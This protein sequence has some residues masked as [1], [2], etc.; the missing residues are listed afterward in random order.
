MNT[1]QTKKPRPALGNIKHY[2]NKMY[3]KLSTLNYF[4]LKYYDFSVKAFH[5][6]K[7]K[8]PNVFLLKSF[9]VYLSKYDSFSHKRCHHLRL[10]PM[11]GTR[12]YASLPGKQTQHQGHN[13]KNQTGDR[14]L[15]VWTHFTQV[16][17]NLTI[18]YSHINRKL[19]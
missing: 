17:F 13:G 7:K 6:R 9:E 11:L 2:N 19:Q 16:G 3:L 5:T 10:A 15:T 1:F 12:W 14:L 8:S 18:C 4:P